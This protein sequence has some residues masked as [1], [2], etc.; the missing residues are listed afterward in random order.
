[1]RSAIQ[2]KSQKRTE[3]QPVKSI[4]QLS[5]LAIASGA[6]VLTA[7]CASVE[8]APVAGA[9]AAAAAATPSAPTPATAGEVRVN[10]T[11]QSPRA[12]GLHECFRLETEKGSKWEVTLTGTDT[13]L[14]VGRGESC[15]N[16]TWDKTNDD[17][18][19]LLFATG[20]RIGF[21][22]GGGAYLIKAQVLGGGTGSFNMNIEN[23]PDAD[24]AALPP[25][26]PVFEA[27]TGSASTVAG[28]ASEKALVVGQPFRD[29]ATCPEMMPLPAGSF[30]MG[31]DAFEPGRN[32]NEGP[33]HLVTFARPFAMGRYEITFAEY[34]ACA[35]EGACQRPADQG[36]G[37]ERRPVINVNY[38]DAQ[39]Y[40]A[41]LSQKTGQLY[42]IPSEAEW[43]YASRAGSDTPWN[44]GTAILTDDANFLG[45][46][47]KTVPVA[48]YPPNAFGLHDMHGNVSEW[49]QDCL[50]TGYLGV[51]ADGSPAL[52]GNCATA[53]LVRG[54]A[55]SH[56]PAGLRSAS[57][58]TATGATQRSPAIGF[59]VARAL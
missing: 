29:C 35:S 18:N 55:Y 25:G 44:T 42:F 6:L 37:R 19:V 53:R 7:S 22:S 11:A 12:G 2:P 38:N 5:H 4:A 8:Y 40:V 46:F 1:M 43:E 54:G 41:W 23:K 50:D 20:S 16:A 58:M 24:F 59:R 34:D 21:T 9:S 28:H 51:P 47:N 17:I 3:E 57:R 27:P 31:S 26:A 14:S 48:S 39:A 56:E 33:R 15:A 13:Y 30:M 32:A 45:Q 36:W 10:V 49:V 52:S